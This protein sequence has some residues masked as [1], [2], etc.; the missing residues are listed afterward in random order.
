MELPKYVNIKG[1]L[2]LK[3]L[4]EL[5]KKRLCGDELAEI[6]GRK[7]STK[8]TPGT[9]YPA[10]KFL[11]KKK[12]VTYKRSGRKKNYELTEEGLKEY[13]RFQKAFKTIFKE[14]L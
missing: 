8:L 5:K 9:I 10:L 14:F 11:R 6:I 2:T 1:F 13:K 3:M 12:L 4:H 7:L